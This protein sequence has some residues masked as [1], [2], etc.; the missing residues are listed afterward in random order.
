MKVFLVG[1]AVRDQLLGLIPKDKDYVVVGSSPEELLSLGYT[2]V[3]ADFPVFLHPETKDEYALARTE[4]STGEGYGDFN[5][6]F[7]KDVTLEQDLERR[8]LT[9]NAIAQDLETGE[10]IDPFNGLRDI[11]A[12]M[13]RHTSNAFM[14]D[15]VRIL[16]AFR[17]AARYN[18]DIFVDT[19][20]LIVENSHTLQHVTRERV[21][22]ELHKGLAES[23]PHLM[24]GYMAGL[25]IFP[26]LSALYNTIQSPVW[27]PEG[28]V[29]IHTALVMKYAK[30]QGWGVDVMFACLCHDFGKPAVTTETGSAHG[31]EVA[32]VPVIDMFCEKWKVPAKLKRLA[33]IM[34][35]HHTRVHSLFGRGGQSS[36]KPKTIMKLFD[37]TNALNRTDE[38]VAFVRACEADA[39]G[40]GEPV[41]HEPYPQSQYI[42]DCL[43]AAKA[44]DTKVISKPMVEAGKQGTAIGE[45]IRVARIA[46]IRQVAQEYTSY[47]E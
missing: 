9:I 30:E 41:C 14:E 3:G 47:T 26:E 1:G 11:K 15:P 20:E 19:Q 37:A 31:H 16:R 27:H 35:E 44:V 46:A 24:L 40:R 34:S 23:N 32:G 13:I 10:Y 43:Q 2:Q 17:F 6:H 8:D 21:W 22:T 12:Q 42:L 5:V 4:I 45:A 25:P 28:N 29:G 7:G 33:R 38:F 39:K 18:W 36:V